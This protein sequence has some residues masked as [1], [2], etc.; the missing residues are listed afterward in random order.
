[1]LAFQDT[2]RAFLETQQAVIGAYLGSSPADFGARRAP[3]GIPSVDPAVTT[4][5]G[6]EPGPWVGEVRR[7]VAGSE[8]EA[9]Y[10]LDA[11]DDPIA[12]HHTLGGRRI[13]ALD[14]TRKGL[15][16][17]PFAVMAE[18]TAQAAALVVT[19]GQVLV[20]L[21][22]VQAHK[23]VRYE[24]SPV[25]LEMR[26]RCEPSSDRGEERVRVG[27]FNRGIDGRAD[28]PRP[29]FEAVAVFAGSDAGAAAGE[30]LVPGRSAAQPVHG[31]IALRGAVAVPRAGAPGAGRGRRVLGARDRRGLA[32]PALGAVARAGPAREAAHRPDRHR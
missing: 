12:E 1:M 22:Q 15:P 13:S 21:E 3:Y 26:G 30:P 20:K 5:S 14:P 27:L 19:P 11:R 4:I 17:L 7:L 31:R 8:I 6:P 10:L 24:D 25:V 28:A 18:M 9:V 32:R 29:V 16:V 2:M 23:W